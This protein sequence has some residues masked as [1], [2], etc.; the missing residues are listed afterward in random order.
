MAKL[1]RLMAL[2]AV[3]QLFHVAAADPGAEQLVIAFTPFEQT[4]IDEHCYGG[5]P[6]RQELGQPNSVLL[7]R[8]ES[9]MAFS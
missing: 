8:D 7:A 9:S 6:I 3:L 4:L 2:I 1:A 5:L